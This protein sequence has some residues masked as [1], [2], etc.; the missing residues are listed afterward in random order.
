MSGRTSQLPSTVGLSAAERLVLGHLRDVG[1]ARSGARL[2]LAR[3]AACV[4]LPREDVDAAVNGLLARQLLHQHADG[5]VVV[6]RQ[7]GGGEQT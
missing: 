7:P 4:C 2:D 1:R 3:V 6:L 5:R